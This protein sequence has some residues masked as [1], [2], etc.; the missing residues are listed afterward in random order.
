M[1]NPQ[2]PEGLVDFNYAIGAYVPQPTPS[3]TVHLIDIE[4]TTIHKESEEARQQIE[5]QGIEGK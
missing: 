5:E 1:Q 2:V 4:G 3:N